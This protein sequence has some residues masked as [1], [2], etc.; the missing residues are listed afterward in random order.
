MEKDKIES[1]DQNT[2]KE[3]KK[4][5]F[6]SNNYYFPEQLDDINT[7]AK[8]NGTSASRVKR[9]SLDY[10]FK[11][12]ESGK[13]DYKP[14]K[15]STAKMVLSNGTFTAKQIELCKQLAEDLTKKLK[16]EVTAGQ[17]RRDAFRFYKESLLNGDFKFYK[18]ETEFLDN[19]SEDNS[20]Q[21]NTLNNI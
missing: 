16:T 9:D 1:E 2:T 18:P 3:V 20:D 17:I 11:S 10:F 8:A 5:V 6:R 14:E 12:I 21:Y 15:E 19:I 13:I 7:I 4:T